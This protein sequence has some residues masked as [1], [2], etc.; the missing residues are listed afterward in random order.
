MKSADSPLAAGRGLNEVR[1]TFLSWFEARDHAPV[2]SS[3]LVPE[4]DPTLLF[5]NSGM[6][7]FKSI[8]TGLETAPH[9][10]AVT[11]QKCLRAGGKHNDL[12]NVGHTA[13]H[14]TFFEMLGN[15]SFGDYFKERAI[16]LAWRLVTE[17]FAL[18]KERLWVSV[19]IDDDEAHGLWKKVAGLEDS[20][21]LRIAG[22]DNFWSMGDTGPCG[23]CSEIFYDHGE[24]VRG[25]PPGSAEQDGDRFTEIWNLVFMQFEQKEGGERVSLPRPSIDTGMGL[26]RMGAVLQGVHDNYETDLFRALIAAS[27]RESGV[28]AASAA[29]HAVSHRVIA[30][31][32]RACGFLIAD[33]VLPDNEGRGYVL[34]RIMRRAMRHAFLLGTDAPLLWRLSGDLV[35]CMGASHPELV[36]AEALIAETLKGEETR[37]RE[38]LERG[39][40]LLRDASERLPE[41]GKLAGEVAFKLYDTYGFPLDLTEDVLREQGRGVDVAGFEAA[42]ARQQEASRAGWSGSGDRGAEPVWFRVRERVG[43]SGFL[44]YER[45]AA[46]SVVQALVVG[47]EEV[48][49]VAGGGS[50]ADE[51]WLVAEETPFYAESGGQVGDCGV[52]RRD[53]GET[54]AVVDTQGRGEGLIA[55]RLDAAGAA[56]LKTPLRVGE[57]VSLE[58]D[59]R[60]RRRIRRHHSAT[61]LLHE[62]L[63]RV[64]GSHVAQKGSLVDAEHLRFDIS[65]GKPVTAEEMEDIEDMVN[66][67][68]LENSAVETRVM[69][70]DEALAGGALALF[71][72]RY[73]EKVRVLFMGEKEEA[74]AWSVELCGGTHVARLGDIGLF[75]IVGQSAVSAGVRRIEAV[76]GEAAR[77]HMLRMGALAERSATVLRT[78]PEELPARLERLLEERKGLEKALE[79]ARRGGGRAVALE[80]EAMPGGGSFTAQLLEDSDGKEL[81]P[82]MDDLKKRIGS[83]VVALVG[84]GEGKARMVVGVTADMAGRIDAREVARAAAECLGGKGGG[85]RP[86]MAQ[87][88]GGNVA[89]VKAALEAAR[90]RAFELAAS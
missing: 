18:P 12:D 78:T 61:H 20:R 26:E 39:L 51:V 10:R 49:E 29:E 53:G 58:V 38:T 77:R 14:H 28:A 56:G 62:A 50:A 64:L 16:E 15:F 25:G 87:C 76:A 82:M 84:A 43:A 68:I 7:Q 83:G 27:E 85:G 21:I 24:H 30:D 79:A 80:Q 11:A 46:E 6:A 4:R 55:H 13:R 47:G 71:G 60:R 88:G 44:G 57:K 42:M 72:E 40:A 23:P 41:G 74:R 81:L 67:R 70:Q 36:R 5:T 2:P 3:P 37:F 65:H 52:L 45:E 35:G 69:S 8:F 32:L 17:E 22:S 31:H 75:K 9:P 34:R 33:G 73:G 54:V 90:E 86:D 59:G 1:A 66:A 89:G 48:A 19:Y 63:R